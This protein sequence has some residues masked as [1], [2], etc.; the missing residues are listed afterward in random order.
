MRTPILLLSPLLALTTLPAQGDKQLVDRSSPLQV[1]EPDEGDRALRVT[2]VVRAVQRAA[3]SVVSIYLQ[4]QLASNRPVTEGQGSGVLL[5]DSGLII[6]NWHVIAPVLLGERRGRNYGVIVKLRD[7]RQRKARILSSTP[8]RDLALLQ[9]EHDSSFQQHS[10]FDTMTEF[11]RQ[12]IEGFADGAPQ[13]HHLVIKAHPLEDGRT[14]LRQSVRSLARAQGR[15]IQDRDILGAGRRRLGG[16]DGIG[17]R[18]GLQTGTS[19]RQ[20][21]P[22]AGFC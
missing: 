22:G 12:V 16:L 10:P 1:V 4:H 6:T 14:P 19:D 21:T 3:D 13:H 15:E 18:G 8:V 11:L 7:G 2:P 5:D 20:I 17:H 9:L